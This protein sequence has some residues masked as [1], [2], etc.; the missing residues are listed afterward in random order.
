MSLPVVMTVDDLNQRA[1]SYS[2]PLGYTISS[3]K[4]GDEKYWARLQANTDSFVSQR[5]ALTHFNDEFADQQ[6]D[7]QNRCYFLHAPEK[8]YIGTA[9][10][11][12]A[13]EPFDAQFGRLHWVAIDPCYRSRGLGKILIK[14][15]MQRLLHY[16]SSVY[17]TSQTSSLAAIDIYL[18]LGFRPLVRNPLDREAWELVKKL[19]EDRSTAKLV[20]V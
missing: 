8:K 20:D 1:I 18:G 4:N 6:I 2:L 15:T 19:L 12:L 10:A 13:E 9:M 5:T 11:W 7:L 17:L 14:Y 16:A 3:F